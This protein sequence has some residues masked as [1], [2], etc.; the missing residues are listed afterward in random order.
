M[1]WFVSFLTRLHSE[2]RIVSH[3]LTSLPKS[4]M[5]R[6][7]LPR[8]CTFIGRN[9]LLFILTCFTSKFHHECTTKKVKLQSKCY[10]GTAINAD[11]FLRIPSWRHTTV[12]NAI[13]PHYSLT[14]S[15]ICAEISHDFADGSQLF[16]KVRGAPEWRFVL[17][18]L[19]CERPFGIIKQVMLLLLSP[20]LFTRFLKEFK[21]TAVDVWL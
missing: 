1:L 12:D 7:K 4:F 10:F 3:F 19:N 14:S 16:S 9:V 21:R 20:S 6:S 2:Y 11:S 5:F 13:Y 18:V 17:F 15:L 8:G